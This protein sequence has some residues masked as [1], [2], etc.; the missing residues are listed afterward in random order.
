MYGKKDHH[1]NHRKL[2]VSIQQRKEMSLSSGKQLKNSEI[3]EKSSITD[4]LAS[5]RSKLL[6][7]AKYE[8][9]NNLF[10]VT[11]LMEKSK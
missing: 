7:Y 6:H 10:N 4:D 5:L 3:Y 8:C 1:K 9:D 11:P 2:L